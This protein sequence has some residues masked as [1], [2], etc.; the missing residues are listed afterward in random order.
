MKNVPFFNYKALYINNRQEF[1]DI[2]DDVCSR[3]AFI[4]QRDLEELKNDHHQ[5]V[6]LIKNEN[7]AKL[8]TLNDMGKLAKLDLFSLYIDDI[9]YYETLSNIKGLDAHSNYL[10][11]NID[12]LA[13]YKKI[14]IL[15]LKLNQ[16][17]FRKN[18]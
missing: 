3:G 14:E 9:P 16:Y 6:E 11:N 1:I 5:V 18:I 8:K 15:N 10:Q 12:G 17:F 2:F 7:I 4:L 13:F